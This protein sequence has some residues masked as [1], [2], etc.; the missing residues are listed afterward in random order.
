M[1]NETSE[2]GGDWGGLDKSYVGLGPQIVF[3][4]P[5]KSGSWEVWCNSWRS[6]QPPAGAGDHRIWAGYFGSSEVVGC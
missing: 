5:V 6:R 3:A 4:G 1:F 2:S